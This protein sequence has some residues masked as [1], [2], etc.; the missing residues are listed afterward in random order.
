LTKLMNQLKA[1]GAD[2]DTALGRMMNDDN[3]YGEMLSRFESEEKLKT[4]K[5]VARRDP[6][7]GFRMAHDLKGTAGLLGLTPLY[8]AV[9]MVVEDLRGVGEETEKEPKKSIEEDLVEYETQ[10]QLY[11]DMVNDYRRRSGETE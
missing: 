8:D 4:L 2:P 7:E 1:W 5:D 9:S 3:F 11:C 6:K 10:R